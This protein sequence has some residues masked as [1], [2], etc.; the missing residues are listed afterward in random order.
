MIRGPEGPE[1]YVLRSQIENLP[2]RPPESLFSANS[3]GWNPCGW[4]RSIWEE[5]TPSGGGVVA[6]LTAEEF[7]LLREA[8]DERRCRDGTGAGVHS[9]AGAPYR[10]TWNARGTALAAP[11]GTVSSLPASQNGAAAAAAGGLPP[12]RA[13]SLSTVERRSLSGSLSLDSCAP[14]SPSSA[15]PS[16][17]ASPTRR[18]SGGGTACSPRYPAS[19]T[20]PCCA[21]PS[22][23][24][25][26]TSTTRPLQRLREAPQARPIPPEALHLR[27]H[28]HLK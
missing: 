23:S 21:T 17:S 12:S 20:V 7:Q 10:R 6:G 4:D 8:V 19:R 18:P 9:E 15:R 11:G 26:G 1:C 14:S 2:E 5:R 16:C 3:F 27:R 22:G 13:P 24:T 28:R 25:R